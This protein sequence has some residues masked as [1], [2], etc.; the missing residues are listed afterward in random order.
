MHLHMYI[1]TMP[2]PG[3]Q[4]NT[5]P[6]ANTDADTDTDAYANHMASGSSGRRVD[7]C[8]CSAASDLICLS[9]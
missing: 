2:S 1:H 3:T 9:N 7:G 5:D 8:G 6:D 4:P